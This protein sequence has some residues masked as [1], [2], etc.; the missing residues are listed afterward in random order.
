M[1]EL[2]I[3]EPGKDVY[4]YIMATEPTYLNSVNHKSLPQSVCLYM[5]LVFVARKF[6]DE[7][8]SAATF[9]LKQTL[10]SAH[11]RYFA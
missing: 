6:R 3:I 7:S 5:Y 1:S 10:L 4:M 2:V 8:I 11:G 9:I